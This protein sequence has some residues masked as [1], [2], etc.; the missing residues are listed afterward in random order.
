M[1]VDIILITSDNV[2]VEYTYISL[3]TYIYIYIYMLEFISSSL[4]PL[5]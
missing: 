2:Y 4:T 5:F 1:I 3:Y